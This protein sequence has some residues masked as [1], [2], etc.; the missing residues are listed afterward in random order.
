MSSAD[1]FTAEASEFTSNVS[2]GDRT[3][4]HKLWQFNLVSAISV[5]FQHYCRSV[6][7]PAR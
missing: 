1:E 7:L 3:T 2:K 5:D 4:S 6:F